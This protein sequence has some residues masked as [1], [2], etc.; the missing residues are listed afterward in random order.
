MTE[1]RLLVEVIDGDGRV[2]DT[3]EVPEITGQPMPEPARPL[4]GSTAPKG[5]RIPPRALTGE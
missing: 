4:S 3:V 2:L 5:V 1:R